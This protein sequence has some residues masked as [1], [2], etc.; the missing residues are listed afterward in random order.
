M[1]LDEVWLEVGPDHGSGSC[2]RWRGLV[3]T[4]MSYNAGSEKGVGLEPGSKYHVG[5][6][7]LHRK[8]DNALI[9]SY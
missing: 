7:L 1:E 6:A 8:C 5:S 3:R 9:L 2:V 4:W